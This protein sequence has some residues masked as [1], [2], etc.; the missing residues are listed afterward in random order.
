MYDI[1]FDDGLWWITY[2]GKKLDI[3]GFIDPVSPEIIIEEI[4]NE[5]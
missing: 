2:N 4:E 3:D 5:I 1:I